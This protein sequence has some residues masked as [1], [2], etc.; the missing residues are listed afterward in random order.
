MGCFYDQRFISEFAVRTRENQKR[1]EY[2]SDTTL[3]HEK[4]L[5]VLYQMV[6]SDENME[7]VVSSVSEIAA[8]NSLISKEEKISSD[9]LRRLFSM[10]GT[11]ERGA[12]EAYRTLGFVPPYFYFDGT[13]L[14]NSFLGLVVLPFERF[15]C[16]RPIEDLD[17]LMRMDHDN[18]RWIQELINEIHKDNIPEDE[19]EFIYSDYSYRRGERDMDHNAR[20][21]V[22]YFWKHLRNAFAHSGDGT[23]FFFP[24]A[25]G[26]GKDITHIGFFDTTE[27]R[28]QQYRPRYFLAKLSLDKVRELARRMDSIIRTVE[29]RGIG[30]YL[31]APGTFEEAKNK[32]R[33]RL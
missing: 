7:T 4:E 10:H 30:R 2:I 22:Y 25:D 24:I 11:F 18:Y 29:E 6:Q 15:N 17:R 32:A 31:N 26:N 13:Q 12:R 16:I 5:E 33:L 28:N 27:G 14:L 8:R 1:I 21:Q 23:I 9:L 19:T 3:N 20:Y